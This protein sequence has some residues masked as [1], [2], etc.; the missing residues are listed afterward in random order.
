MIR[1]NYENNKI[2]KIIKIT[3]VKRIRIIEKVYENIKF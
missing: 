3:E 2:I 1:K